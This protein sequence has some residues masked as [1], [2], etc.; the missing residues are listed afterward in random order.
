MPVDNSDTPA[1]E[2]T[3]P[4]GS[5][6]PKADYVEFTPPPE[7]AH[8]DAPEGKEIDL[9]CSFKPTKDGKWTMT[10]LGEFPMP[11]A[12]EKKEGEAKEKPDWSGEAQATVSDLGRAY[13]PG[14]ET[15]P[16]G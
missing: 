6:S 2:T 3:M 7:A 12:P 11:D 5:G 10:K 1:P 9:V 14:G 15:P 16:M 8:I 4:A 13:G